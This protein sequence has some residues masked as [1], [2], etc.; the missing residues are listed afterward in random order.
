MA[1]MIATRDAYGKALVEL[2]A[3]KDNIVLNQEKEASFSDVEEGTWYSDNV[4]KAASAGIINGYPDGTFKPA[5]PA[6]K[7]EAVVVLSRL[8]KR[9]KKH[10]NCDNYN[11]ANPFKDVNTNYWAYDILLEAYYE[12][13]C[14]VD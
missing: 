8:Y 9:D 3:E 11:K 14:I 12:H 6:T 2:G 7:T 13:S 4:K 10:E 5:E 1:D